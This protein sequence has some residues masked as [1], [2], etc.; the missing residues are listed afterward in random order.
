MFSQKDIIF[1]L[2]WIFYKLIIMQ[3]PNTTPDKAKTVKL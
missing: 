2:L 1:K 3:I